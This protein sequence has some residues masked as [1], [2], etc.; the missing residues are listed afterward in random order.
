V[1][2]GTYYTM[3]NH[4][5]HTVHMVLVKYRLQ[6]SGQI[7]CMGGGGDGKL[8]DNIHMDSREIGYKGVNWI[9]L[10]Q[11]DTCMHTIQTHNF[12]HIHLGS[13]LYALQTCCIHNVQHGLPSSRTVP[14]VLVTRLKGYT[15]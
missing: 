6:S 9:R 15:T 3:R 10:S 4:T 14:S 7:A 1:R 2:N 12:S 11:N 5:I 13:L 8:A